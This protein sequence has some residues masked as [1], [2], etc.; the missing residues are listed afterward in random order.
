VAPVAA[1][2]DVKVVDI[3]LATPYEVVARPGAAVV[4]VVAAAEV[5]LATPYEVVA[6]PEAAVLVVADA[7]NVE[8]AVIAPATPYAVVARPGAALVLVVAAADVEAAVVPSATPYAFVARPGA[9]LVVVVA[10][11]DVEAA[12]V[13]LATPYAVVAR[14]GAAL[15]L[16]VA[17]TGVEAADTPLEVVATKPDVTAVLGNAADAVDEVIIE[18][19]EVVMALEGDCISVEV[20]FPSPMIITISVRGGI[21]VV[22]EAFLS[23]FCCVKCSTSPSGLTLTAAT[24]RWCLASDALT[25][26]VWFLGGSTPGVRWTPSIRAKLVRNSTTCARESINR[27]GSFGIFGNYANTKR[28]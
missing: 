19:A 2:A 11:A 7:T 9:A 15:V 1:A 22:V 20:F 14:P 28:V 23:D 25:N 26:L 10:A 18:A 6:G 24:P 3:P 17:A 12:V 16:V 5:P 27:Y 8:A 13:P 4:L 21:V